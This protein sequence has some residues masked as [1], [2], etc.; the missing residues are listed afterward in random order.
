VQTPD[1]APTPDPVENLPMPDPLPTRDAFVS[2]VGTNASANDASANCVFLRR[3]PPSCAP[4]PT[5]LA[6]HAS[7]EHAMDCL[8]PRLRAVEQ[9][10]RNF[11]PQQPQ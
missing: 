9:R 5:T 3:L 1:V 8:Q 2:V 10:L 7:R 6:R 4:H 11:T